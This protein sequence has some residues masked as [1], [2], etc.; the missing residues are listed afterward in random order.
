M[1][2]LKS[3]AVNSYP[4]PHSIHI[5]AL[6]TPGYDSPN[7]AQRLLHL[8]AY[9]VRAKGGHPDSQAQHSQ[10]TRDPQDL[11]CHNETA[12]S[13]HNGHGYLHHILVVNESEPQ[14]DD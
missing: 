12:Q 8:P 1:I 6:C 9:V 2:K 10:H 5:A 4:N 3:C 13:S 14:D 11:I 7:N